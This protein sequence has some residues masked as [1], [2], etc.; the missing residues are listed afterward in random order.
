M[1]LTTQSRQLIYKGDNLL[2]SKPFAEGSVQTIRALILS[3]PFDKGRSV[4]T[5]EGHAGSSK[6]QLRSIALRKE[7]ERIMNP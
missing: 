1:L 7:S 4:S 5:D 3:F 2:V 6:F